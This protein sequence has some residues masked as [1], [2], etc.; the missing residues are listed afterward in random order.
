MRSGIRR[1]GVAALAISAAACGDS[2]GPGGGAAALLTAGSYVDYDTASTGAESSQL[3]FTLKSFGVTVTPVNAIDSANLATILAGT[4]A[5]VIPEV[6][7][8]I[9]LDLTEGAKTVL[10]RFVD[11]TGGVL[12][13]TADGP[14]F[15]L[16]DTLFTYSIV[17]GPDSQYTHLD[18]AGA[19]GTP[20]AGGPSILY[21]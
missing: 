18:A 11:S 7:G 10:R 13:V 8:D 17:A 4:G 21:E 14:G 15:A 6:G 1:G 9:A 20:F 19:A 12:I 16:L 5:F 2:N 3:E